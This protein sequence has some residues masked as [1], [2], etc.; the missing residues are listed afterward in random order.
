MP[1]IGA[2][3]SR[4]WTVLI[5]VGALGAASGCG[6]SVEP[7]ATDGDAGAGASGADAV[8]WCAA[9]QIINCVCQQCHQ[10][11]PLHG[12]PIPLLTYADT[13]VP[14]TEASTKKVWEEMQTVIRD[15]SMPYTGDKTIM[16]LVQP[17]N[18]EQYDTMLTWLNEGAHDKGGQDCPQ[19]C[20]WSKG[21]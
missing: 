6:S 20:D 4:V 12:A 3:H 19:T 18:D 7:S 9:Y 11:P 14:V 13:Q 16:P 21:Q 2:T 8:T 5:F 1:I 15:Y 10:D 17:L